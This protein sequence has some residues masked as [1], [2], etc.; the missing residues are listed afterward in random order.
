MR[1]AERSSSPLLV[2]TQRSARTFELTQRRE[3]KHPPPNQASYKHA[4]AAR[5]Q[6][7]VSTALAL[8]TLSRVGCMP[9]L[10]GGL[11]ILRRPPEKF[12]QFPD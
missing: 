11:C 2:L 3:S 4:P 5:V 7:F 1:V 6:R 8:V 12:R 10:E 9:L